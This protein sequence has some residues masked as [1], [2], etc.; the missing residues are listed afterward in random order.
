M[1]AQAPVQRLVQINDHDEPCLDRNAVQGDESDPD[2][3]REIVPEEKDQVHAADEGERNGEHDGTRFRKVFR[4]QVEHDENDQK[5]RRH[6]DLQ[7]LRGSEMVLP[8]A[9]PLES[10]SLR[11]LKPLVQ[12]LS[13][14]MDKSSHIPPPHAELDGDIP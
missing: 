6:E 13:R 11:E 7:T 3:H 14:V 10:V 2:G 4:R 1:I 12:R 9:A 5:D 8:L